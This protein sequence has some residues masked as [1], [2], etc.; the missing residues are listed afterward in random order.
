M[1]SVNANDIHI[2]TAVG[3]ICIWQ[4]LNYFDNLKSGQG[5]ILLQRKIVDEKLIEL[6]ITEKVQRLENGQPVL[7][8][9]QF[10]SISHSKNWFCVYVASKPIGVDV[11]HQRPNLQ[12]GRSY[13]VNEQEEHF[14]TDLQALQ[15]IWGA[16][17]A[18]Y[19][20]MSAKI[21]DLKLDVKMVSL[22][23]ENQ[24]LELEYLGK[25]HVL[26]YRM[27]NELFLVYT[28]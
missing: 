22:D 25:K 3:Q 7:K 16:K 5:K 2:Q 26:I 24:K 19:K 4:D 13:F 28:E 21:D 10:I 14:S 12:A 15:L 9:G 17:E 8:S 27:M 6:G 1:D 18:F 23:R 11:E 20:Q